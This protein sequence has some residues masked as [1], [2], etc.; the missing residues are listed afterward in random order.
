MVFVG[1]RLKNRSSNKGDIS[2]TAAYIRHWVNEGC[3][4]VCAGT[5]DLPIPRLAVICVEVPPAT[6]PLVVPK[7]ESING[8]TPFGELT[9]W[10]LE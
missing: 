9:D 1:T 6:K 4:K 8:M 7:G 10:R 5:T 3:E 2:Y